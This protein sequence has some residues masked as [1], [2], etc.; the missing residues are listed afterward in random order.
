MLALGRGLM[1]RPRL[2]LLDDPFI[3]LAPRL[4][5]GLCEALR[6]L[7]ARR[8]GILIAGQHVGRILGLAGRAYLLEQ[9]RITD[10]SPGRALLASPGLRRALLSTP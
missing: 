5:A 10:E 1:T 3:G 7:A 4:I 9:G 6:A 8:I 2:F